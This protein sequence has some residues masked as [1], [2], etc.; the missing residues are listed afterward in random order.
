MATDYAPEDPADFEPLSFEELITVGSN[1]LGYTFFVGRLK[2]RWIGFALGT[3]Q[4]PQGETGMIFIFPEVA[5]QFVLGLPDRDA[6]IRMTGAI[7][8]DPESGY[9]GISQWLQPKELRGDP[10]KFR[11]PQCGRIGCQGDCETVTDFLGEKP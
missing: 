4:R 6:A 11:C 3:V 8:Q 9:G 2:G 5:E 1:D 10:A 7:A